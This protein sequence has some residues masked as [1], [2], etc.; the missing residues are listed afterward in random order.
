MMLRV[1]LKKNQGTNPGDFLQLQILG[2]SLKK[3][4]E[5]PP[6]TALDDRRIPA[7]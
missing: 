5:K 7:A 2:S 6:K 3:P 1:H 4:N